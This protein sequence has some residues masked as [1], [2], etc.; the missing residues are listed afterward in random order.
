MSNKHLTDNT[1]TTACIILHLLMILRVTYEIINTHD[2]LPFLFE[3][4]SAP[5]CVSNPSEQE[6]E[7]MHMWYNSAC[8]FVTTWKTCGLNKDI[9]NTIR[10]AEKWLQ[11]N[12]RTLPNPI[13][14]GSSPKS[15]PTAMVHALN[16]AAN[17]KTSKELPIEFVYDFYTNLDPFEATCSTEQEWFDFFSNKWTD[18]P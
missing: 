15:P 7:C 4:A 8:Q 16:R 2:Y 18:N 10:R 9:Q 12:N 6:I 17:A 3:A 11:K 13:D 5:E 1:F 14:L